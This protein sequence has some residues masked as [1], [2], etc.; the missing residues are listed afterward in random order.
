MREGASFKDALSIGMLG[1]LEKRSRMKMRAVSLVVSAILGV[2]QLAMA[3][4]STANDQAASG[5]RSMDCVSVCIQP[6]TKSD[7]LQRTS[8]FPHMGS[9]PVD[10]EQLVVARSGIQRQRRPVHPK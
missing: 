5:A 9:R 4:A 10:E 7:V 2:A 6:S 3:S 8:P 1:S